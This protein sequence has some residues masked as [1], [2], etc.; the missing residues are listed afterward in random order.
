MD[1]IEKN[2]RKKKVLV[3]LNSLI[4]EVL[5]EEYPPFPLSEKEIEEIWASEDSQEVLSVP[6]QD[7]ELLIKLAKKHKGKKRHSR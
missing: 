1:R 2:S 5:R 6:F 4:F 7:P 3:N